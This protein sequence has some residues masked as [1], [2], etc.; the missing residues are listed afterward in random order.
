MFPNVR[1]CHGCSGDFAVH[2]AV[3]MFFLP[4]IISLSPFGIL[5]YTYRCTTLLHRCRALHIPACVLCTT[6]L[7]TTMYVHRP[8]HQGGGKTPAGRCFSGNFSV[9]TVWRK[10]FDDLQ[11]SCAD[12]PCM[13]TECTPSRS[14]AQGGRSLSVTSRAIGQ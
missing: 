7:C 2:I 13:T 10:G 14:P 8:G 12:T 3:R 11:S 1:C 6:S 4:S 5:E 9:R